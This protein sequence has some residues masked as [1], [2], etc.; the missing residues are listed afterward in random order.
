M[1]VTIHTKINGASKGLY[2]VQTST[3]SVHFSACTAQKSALDIPSHTCLVTSKAEAKSLQ[4]IWQRPTFHKWIRTALLSSLLSWKSCFVLLLL[5]T[6]NYLI[7]PIRCHIGC[8][9]LENRF[10]CVISTILKINPLSFHYQQNNHSKILI[11][12]KE[13]GKLSGKATEFL[14]LNFLHLSQVFCNINLHSSFPFSS[15]FWIAGFLRDGSE[16]D[17]KLQLTKSIPPNN[18][19]KEFYSES[20][21]RITIIPP[22]I[23]PFQ[24]HDVK[25]SI[26]LRGEHPYPK[27]FS[28]YLHN[29]T[30]AYKQAYKYR[31]LVTKT[32]F[33][34]RI[35]TLC[36][37]SGPIKLLL[38]EKESQNA[39][40]CHQSVLNDETCRL[41][42]TISLLASRSSWCN[43][44]LINLLSAFNTLG[45][46]FWQL[47][48]QRVKNS[49]QVKRSLCTY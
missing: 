6:T 9:L 12:N 14:C 30:Q 19:P 36:T 27:Y 31:I 46:L 10:Y 15:A 29:A 3:V 42:P 22:T 13:V 44:N 4:K 40:S 38:K 1:Y 45:T 25:K 37:A 35:L 26:F 11:Y 21:G 28:K 33:F 34:N 41:S 43:G 48:T 32:K 47:V 2:H 20:Q 39:G 17:R 23:F 8:N 16:V 24:M 18:S 7:R 49:L 5:T